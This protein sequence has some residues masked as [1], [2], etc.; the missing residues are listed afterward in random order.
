VDK[1][2][3]DVAIIGVGRVGL[4]LGL[5]LS[6]FGLRCIGIDRD[7]GL[8]EKV[9]S[10]QMPFEEPGFEDV[11]K[12]VDFRITDDYAKLSE[13][14][15]IIITVGTPLLA[16]IETDLSQISAVVREIARYLKK[17]QNIILRSTVAPKTTLF[18]KNYLEKATGLEIGKDV[19]LSFCPERIVEGKA[20][21]ELQKLPQI[22][23]AEDDGSFVKAESV[24]GALGNKILR[25]SYLSAELVKLFLNI[26][27]YVSFAVANQFAIVA[28]EFGQNIFEIIKCANEDYPRGGI[29]APGFTAGTCLR[30]DFGMVN[31]NI[32]YM[33]LMLSAWKVNE[34][35]P[36]YLV[37]GILGRTAAKGKR[38]AI[39]GY[40]FK[41]DA[42]DTR[43]SLAPK[44]IRYVEREVPEKIT[45]S[46]PLIRGKIEGYE[47]VP[48]LDAVKSADIVFVSVNHSDFID[49][50]ESIINAAQNGTW[51][52]DIWN[53]L[54][55]NEM[56]FKTGLSETTQGGAS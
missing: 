37:D 24:F 22:I 53:A 16:H 28:D 20:Y 10:R 6:K 13:A 47:N 52:V 26:S 23:G 55:K 42:D 15:H 33:D 3:Y 54:G 32:P 51:F 43:D 27:R 21:E 18:V 14:S 4:P 31:E 29:F 1:F 11:L 34:F 39:L 35:M 49:N 5:M 41:R 9:N 56:F 48:F 44:L 30:K 17:S 45:I 19:F 12:E 2:A 46:D 50:S 8:A 40:A 36:K 25:T 38:I 7:P